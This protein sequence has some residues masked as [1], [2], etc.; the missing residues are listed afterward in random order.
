MAVKEA[1]EDEDVAEEN[2]EI[3]NMVWNKQRVMQHRRFFVVSV[4][5][6]Y[7]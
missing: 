5:R 1:E 7:K 2:A 4:Q 6:F 3:E